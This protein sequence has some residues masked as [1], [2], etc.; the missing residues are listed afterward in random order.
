[1]TGQAIGVKQFEKLE[2]TRYVLNADVLFDSNVIRANDPAAEQRLLALSAL[3]VEKPDRGHIWFSLTSLA[4][5]L[6]PDDAS[7]RVELLKRF[8][9]LYRQFG[10]RVRFFGPGP[11]SFV[12]AEWGDKGPMYSPANAVDDDV[13]ASIAAGDLV[14]SLRLARQS[15]EIERA[16]LWQV[17]A[18]KVKRYRAAYESD[19]VFRD[20]F[21][22][23][24]ELL[25]TA[26]AL[27]QCDDIARSLIIDH[28]KRS[29]SALG[30]AKANPQNYPCTWTYSLLVRIADY[31]A[32]LK[33]SEWKAKY[34]RYG[35]LLKSDENDYVD[36]YIAATGGGCGMIITNDGGLVDKVNFL[37]DAEPS[38]VR[39]QGFTVRDAVIAYNPPNGDK[40][41]RSKPIP[42][43]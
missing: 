2:K 9:N 17:H 7:K 6:G 8:Q 40:R 39:L 22:R 21:K 1:M 23:N 33:K 30:E 36:A 25:G 10:D 34:S 12:V 43:V 38:L 29:E 31:S 41:D 18:D 42:G 11:F 24:V 19:Q 15:W 20:E 37:H 4:E 16:R 26:N 3:L 13:C 35:R 14:G 28:A 5:L 27:E 32:T